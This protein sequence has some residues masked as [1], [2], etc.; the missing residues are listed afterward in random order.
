MKLSTGVVRRRRD[1]LSLAIAVS[2]TSTAAW[3]ASPQLRL[4]SGDSTFSTAKTFPVQSMS[5]EQAGTSGRLVV[6]TRAGNISC[7]AS[8]SVPAGLPVLRLDGQT[9]P[10]AQF[11]LPTPM[12]PPTDGNPPIPVQYRVTPGDSLEGMA[13]ASIAGIPV[14]NCVSSNLFG[15]PS[16]G[17]VFS[18]LAEDQQ[19]VDIAQAV[20]YDVPTR[21]FE[22]RSADPILCESYGTGGV[23]L[24]LAGPNNPL[25]SVAPGDAMVLPGFSS[26][27]YVVAQRS[28]RPVSGEVN[29]SPLVQ[30]SV[31]GANVGGGGPQPTSSL[32]GS[33]FEVSE[34]AANVKLF[35]TV[36]GE[37]APV[38]GGAL[39]TTTQIVL[40]VQNDG[41]SIA[42]NVRIREY[43][44]LQAA[45]D[46]GLAPVQV[47]KAAPDSCVIAA[48]T[49]PCGGQA[50]DPAFPLAFNLAELGVGQA[51]EFTLNRRATAGAVGASTPVGF[52]AF[53][54]P[55]MSNGSGPDLDLADNMAW[56]T[57]AVS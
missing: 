11:P 43:A 7:G 54:D 14:A 22:V 3:A 36:N 23:T 27:G 52:A 18:L 16:S 28:L 17:G 38:L 26:V 25:F 42:R 40:R 4:L 56:S 39:G 9:Y 2:L 10:L 37:S 32:F 13:L 31:P 19:P 46:A 6:N 30:C 47:G 53:V 45:F 48:G 24:V 12:Q 57:F 50:T 5:F 1:A 33:G 34:G 15:S 35:L 20:Y 44:P 21:A 51:V 49:A 55:A 41:P 29:R 8:Q